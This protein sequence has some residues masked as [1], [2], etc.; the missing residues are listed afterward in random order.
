M[1][2]LLVRV[3]RVLHM[4]IGITEPPPAQEKAVA[5]AWLLLVVLLVTVF[6]VG[7]FVIG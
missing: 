1:L 2:G 3:V 4:T 5:L 6:V 7:L